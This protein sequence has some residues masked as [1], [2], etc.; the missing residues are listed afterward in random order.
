MQWM[1]ILSG[2]QITLDKIK[3]IKGIMDCWGGVML[4]EMDSQTEAEEREARLAEESMRLVR[5]LNN[6]YV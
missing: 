1:S 2:Q 5:L 6:A 4:S 3:D